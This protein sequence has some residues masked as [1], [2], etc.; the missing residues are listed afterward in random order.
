MSLMETIR[1][2]AKK[3]NKCIVLPEGT[4][5]RT[6]K[7]ADEILGENLARLILIGNPEEIMKKSIE[8]GLA[9]INKAKII[10][11]ENN[12]DHE[13][14]AS[15]LFELRKSKGLTFEEASKL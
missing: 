13:K 5:D 2:N 9:N 14:Y 1:V 4:E 10:D 7:A 15:L 12:P 8:F 11:P 3:L 6:L